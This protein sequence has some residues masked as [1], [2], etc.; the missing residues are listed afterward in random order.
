MQVDNI[1]IPAA[2]TIRISKEGKSAVFQT[3]IVQTTDNKYIYALPVHVN[4]KLINF[5]VKGCTKELRVE[6]APFEFYGWKNVSIIKFIED[7]KN[8]LR[9]KTSTRGAKTMLWAERPLN[10]ID[11]SKVI[12]KE[13][14]GNIM[15]EK[16]QQAQQLQEQQL[17]SQQMQPQG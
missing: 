17:Q 8:Y 14:I 11:S 13:I 5:E 9:I 1:P 16:R 4:N 7:G 10:I 15:Q 12:D 2:A 3:T 6:F